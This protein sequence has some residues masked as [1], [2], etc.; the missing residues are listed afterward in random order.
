MRTTDEGYTGRAC[1][2]VP[3]HGRLDRRRLRMHRK[4]AEKVEKDWS[5]YS[6]VKDSDTRVRF[7]FLTGV[8]KLSR[9]SLFSGLNN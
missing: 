9:V 6:V 5:M 3:G 4:I 7:T 8:S 2:E 1:R